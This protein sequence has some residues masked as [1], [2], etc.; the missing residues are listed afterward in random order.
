MTS[1]ASSTLSRWNFLA[2]LAVIVLA[3]TGPTPASAQDP[4]AAKSPAPA[5]DT[6]AVPV[7]PSIFEHWKIHLDSGVRNYDL[8]G[9]H[10]GK[11]LE[12]RDV[13]RGFFVNGAGIRFESAQSPYSFWFEASN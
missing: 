2:S 12:D 3:L 13:T 8:Y 5:K 4:P 9:D 11:F 10:P 7:V 6:P 1:T